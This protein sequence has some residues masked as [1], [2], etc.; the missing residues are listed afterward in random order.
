MNS[1][2]VHYEIPPM[3]GIYTVRVLSVSA[4]N[5]KTHVKIMIPD[6]RVIKVD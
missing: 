1:W 3:R 5:A 4:E 2:I 6:C